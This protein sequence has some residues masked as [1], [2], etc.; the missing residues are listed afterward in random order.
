M[1]FTNDLIHPENLPRY[2]VAPLTPIDLR[3]RSIIL[4]NWLFAAIILAGAVAL[5]FIFDDWY[6]YRWIA[7]IIA[8][9]VVI[10]WGILHLKA[11]E[12]RSYAVRNHDLIYRHGILSVSTT[13]IPFNRIQH[14]SVREGVLSRLYG[15]ASIQVFTAGGAAADLRLKGLARETAEQVKEIILEK[16]RG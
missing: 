8:I 13:V 10:A 4:W 9:P 7:F 15:L 6:A 12:R 1:E 5:F 16:I 11:F 2:E 3:Y 14:V